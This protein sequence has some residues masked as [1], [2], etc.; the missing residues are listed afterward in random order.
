M[1]GRLFLY[2]F[3]GFIGL[4]AIGASASGDGASRLLGDRPPA[5]WQ[6]EMR[7]QI[8]VARD[9]AIRAERDRRYRAG[10]MNLG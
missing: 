8:Q 9:Q 6:G 5:Y 10:E 1:I 4:T 7:S 2:G 3:I